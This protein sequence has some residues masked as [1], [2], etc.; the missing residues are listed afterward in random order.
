MRRYFRYIFLALILGILAMSCIEELDAPQIMQENEELTLVPRVKSFTNHYVTKSDY[1]VGNETKITKLA[2]LVF[3]SDR[4]LVHIQENQ[5]TEGNVISSVTLNKSMLNSPANKDLLTSAT[6]VMIANMDLDKIQNSD[7]EALSGQS[8]L[9]LDDLNDFTFHIAEAQTVV[10]DLTTGFGGFPMVGTQAGVNLSPAK[11][12]PEVTV[13]LQILYAKINFSISVEAGTENQNLV[14][15]S[16]TLSKYIVNNVS[17]RTRYAAPAEG[18]ATESTEYAYQTTGKTIEGSS[19]SFT[20]Y[21]AETRYMPTTTLNGIYPDDSWIESEHFS[22]LK[23][24]YKPKLATTDTGFPATGLATYVTL[25]GTYTDYRGTQWGVN[26]KVYLGKDN[27]QNF[28]VDRNSEYTNIITIKGIRNNDSYYETDSET[29]TMIDKHVW[30]DHR[31]D[32][33]L[34]S[35]SPNKGA[36]CVTITRETLIDSHIEV[37]PLRVNLPDDISV[38]LLYLPK[39][40][41]NVQIEEIEGGANENWIA[42]ENNNGRVKDITQFSSNGKRKYF[43]TSLIEQL[44]LE[45]NDETYGVRINQFDNDPR[46]GQRYIQLQMNKETGEGDCAWIYIDEN[47]SEDDRTATLELVFYN[48]DREAVMEEKF[49]IKQ[50]GLHKIENHDLYIETYEEYLHTY[51]SQDMYTDPTRDYTQRGYNWGLKNTRISKNQ[52]VRQYTLGFTNTNYPYDYFHSEDAAANAAYRVLDASEKDIDLSKNTG[53]HFTNNAGISQEMT[54]IDMST[55]PESAIQYCLSKNKF[56]VDESD[57]E[58]HMMDIHWYLPDAYEMAQILTGGNNDFA[59]FKDNA[60]WTSQPSWRTPS[61]FDEALAAGYI[62]EDVNNARVVSLTSD[63]S[64]SHGSQT[65]RDELHRIR[66]AYSKIG[67][68][69][70]NFSGARAPEGIGAMRFYMRAWKNWDT[71]EPG[72][73]Y[74]GDWIKNPVPTGPTIIGGYTEPDTYAFPKVSADDP[75]NVFGGYKAGYGFKKDP[76]APENQKPEIIDETF[77]DYNNYTVFYKW[78]GL[79]KY[80]IVTQYTFRGTTYYDLGDEKKETKGI[81]EKTYIEYDGDIT[82]GGL[83]PLDHLHEGDDLSITFIKGNDAT[84]SPKYSYYKDSTIVSRDTTRTWILPTYKENF[85]TIASSDYSLRTPGGTIKLST[86]EQSHYDEQ[87]DRTL[88]GFGYK[89]SIYSDNDG[90]VYATPEDAIKAGNDAT[91]AVDA[92]GATIQIPT[93]IERNVTYE[94]SG[95]IEL[96][97]YYTYSGWKAT[98]H[99]VTGTRYRYRITYTIEGEKIPYY[100]YEKD[101]EWKEVA[102]STEETITTAPTTDNLL[103]YGGNSFTIK[104]NNGNVISSVKI[105][106]SD[107]NVV[108]ENGSLVGST[109]HKYLRFTK[110]G[111][112]GNEDPPGMSYSGDGE[113]GTM[114]WSGDPTNEITLELMSYQK[115]Y[116]SILDV[117]WETPSSSEYKDSD[118]ESFEHSIVID[119]IDVRYKKA[120]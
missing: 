71:K 110:D 50:K 81:E 77:D 74:F 26:Y 20:F 58:Q 27:F 95:T 9:S 3:G 13:H 120:D 106:F 28:E 23:Q 14:E 24:Q 29:G 115:S 105:Y 112:T 108:N 22:H 72:Y 107:S 57:Q 12:S 39:Y 98:S 10:T 47:T 117:W 35:D 51:D 62:L 96:Y 76:S 100:E 43:T 68:D 37:R 8:E 114:T 45:N 113:T 92:S 89:K 52:Y 86:D 15:P 88:F 99:D 65:P 94:P 103:M 78:P 48:N 79:T 6:L 40:E 73:F 59:D 60:Y 82:A 75:D 31:V 21:M 53:L 84:Q 70:V 44:H 67:I 104:A 25:N 69:S 33:A 55:R 66:C 54:I 38:A 119:Q 30:I 34:N 97:R 49:I 2:V 32:V 116:N 11:D 56:R 16:F 91:S 19:A 80:K 111:F 93:G 85:E 61:G 118:S 5:A 90:Y 18:E 4:K 41:D 63:G 83:K 42:I 1:D 109:V 102:D 36:D 87:V 17:M 7:G 46:K 101:G 64:A